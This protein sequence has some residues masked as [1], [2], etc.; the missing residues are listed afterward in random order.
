[1]I[2]SS[3]LHLVTDRQLCQGGLPAAAA[4][5]V[6]G[7]VD[8]V[9]LREPGLDAHD[10]LRLALALRESAGVG[11][12]LVINDRLDVA[13]AAGADAVQLGGRSLPVTAVRALV[14]PRLAIGASVHGV[15]EAVRA[16]QAGADYLVLGTIY[17][18]RSHP[19]FAGSG[20][21][22]VREVAARVSIPVFAIGGIVA[23]NIAEVIGAGAQGAVVVSAILAD[24]DPGEAARRLR[25]AIEGGEKQ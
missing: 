2:R 7:G 13:L 12:A 22:L 5:A 3:R 17:P 21:S 16:E 8:V 4:A 11:A 23:E 18:S 20:P 9:H 10:I 6:R 14:G 19:G 25:R 1:M 15:E 24:A